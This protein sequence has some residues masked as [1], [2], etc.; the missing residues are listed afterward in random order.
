MFSGKS[1]A[2]VNHVSRHEAIGRSC[3]VVNHTMDDRCAKEICTHDKVH[4]SAVKVPLLE[5]ID[6]GLIA[7]CECIGIDEGQFFPDLRE[8]VLEWIARGKHVAIAGLSGDFQAKP[9]DNIMHLVPYA[10]E[11]VHK[12]ALC[13]ECG[14]P[15][16]F[17]LRCGASKKRFLSGGKSEY[18]AV[19]RKHFC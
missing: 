1:T 5:A 18:K 2:L 14:M 9:F 6:D 11:V 19:C 13:I 17:S 8:K 4:H 7:S 12:R 16:M 15:A 10:D 3:L